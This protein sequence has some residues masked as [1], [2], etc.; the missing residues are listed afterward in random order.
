MLKTIQE[1][2]NLE[3]KRV[4]LRTDFDVPLDQKSGKVK[5]DFRIK[6]NLE[7]IDFLFK[8]RVKLIIITHLGR[9]KG[10]IVEGLRLKPVYELLKTKYKLPIIYYQESRGEGVK[11]KV[12]KMKT[13]EIVLLENLRFYPEEEKN[14]SSFAKELAELADFFVN[15]AF[16]VSHRRHTSVVEITKYLPSYAGFSLA[17]EIETLSKLKKSFQRP[18]IVLLGGAKIFD[19]ID[20]LRNFKEIADWILVGG[21]L[22]NNFLKA[23]GYETGTSLIEPEKIKEAIKLLENSSSDLEANYNSSFCVDNCKVVGGEK[24]ILPCDLKVIS[25][26]RVKTKKINQIKEIDQI[27]DIGSATIDLF[28]KILLEARTIFWNG[29]MGFFEDKRFASGTEE[30][31]KTILKSKAQVIIGGRDTISAIK[32]YLSEM[33][34]RENIFISVGGGAMLDFLADKSLPGI[35]VLKTQYS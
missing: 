19:K 34:K 13:G 7:T 22:A 28:S 23:E 16:A 25:K 30:I 20:I 8:K 35:E 6:N 5:N 10:K 18:L 32:N 12:E 4:L 24:I 17:R 21:A 31:A 33:K 9:P 1:V 3:G 14:D 2:K 11:K 27:L 26:K 15:D 29:P